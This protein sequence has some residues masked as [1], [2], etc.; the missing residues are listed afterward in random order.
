MP[1]VCVSGAVNAQGANEPCAPWGALRVNISGLGTEEKGGNE[2]VASEMP[3]PHAHDATIGSELVLHE[4]LFLG[5]V[6]ALDVSSLAILV[7]H[8]A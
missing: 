4:E 5:V 2:L 8:Y 6:H 3:T 1:L 7:I